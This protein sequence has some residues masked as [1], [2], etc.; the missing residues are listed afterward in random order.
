[1]A[2]PGPAGRLAGWALESADER[3]P[4]LF[5]HPINRQGGCWFRVA[6]LLEPRRRCLLPDL[7]G[8]GRSDPQGPYGVERWAEDCLAVMDRRGV[9]RAHVVGG[10]L[11][12]TIAVYLAATAPERVASIT[13]IG[14]ALAIEGADLEGVLAV[15]REKGVAGM[16]RE[17]VPEISVAPGT[18]P[19]LIEEILALANPNDVETVGAIW[20]ETIRSDVTSLAGDVR[21]P[22]LV[23]TGELDL[24]CPPEQARA[25]ASALGVEAVVVPGVGHLPMLEAPEFVAGH[26]NGHLAREESRAGGG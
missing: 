15:L 18:P 26:L 21:C 20:A 17:V 25:M 5:V 1:M 11:G 3:A 12:G 16:F 13:A 7:R 22:A 10:S 14:S 24:T 8:H 9:V 2:V 19:E 6:G 23:L 4:V